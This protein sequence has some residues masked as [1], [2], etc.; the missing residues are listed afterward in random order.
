[1]N[2]EALKI[3]ALEKRVA[4]LEQSL[5]GLLGGAPAPF[6]EMGGSAPLVPSEIKQCCEKWGETLE[7]MG[8]RRPVLPHENMKIAQLVKQYGF[9]PTLYALYGYRFEME[10]PSFD[11]RKNVSISRLCESEKLFEKCLGLG[12]A[13]M[14]KQRKKAETEEREQKR[15]DEFR[16]AYP[17]YPILEPSTKPEGSPS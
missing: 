12:A 6:V 7:K 4:A 14:E 13:E 1:M 11:P 2:E 3:A 15:L 9:K 16:R 8:Q 5:R 17:S 10:T